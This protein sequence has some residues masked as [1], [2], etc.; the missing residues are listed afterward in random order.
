MILATPLLSGHASIKGEW[1]YELFLLFLTEIHDGCVGWISLRNILPFRG[2]PETKQITH[3]DL[4]T[5]FHDKHAIQFGH[6][7]SCVSLMKEM[8]GVIRLWHFSQVTE[9]AHIL[10]PSD[11]WGSAVAKIRC[12][13]E[14]WGKE[15]GQSFFI[16]RNSITCSMHDLFTSTRRSY[17]G[18][19][20]LTHLT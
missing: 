3:N 15:C 12:G 10:A 1:V 5:S 13:T 17:F 4:F 16:L 6:W 14:G 18:Q 20:I 19:K 11:L 8:S 7:P 2:K 9:Q